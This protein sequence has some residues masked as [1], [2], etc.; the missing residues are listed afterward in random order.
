MKSSA[1]PAGYRMTRHALLRAHQRRISIT[2][3]ELVLR[4]GRLSRGN[5]YSLFGIPRPFGIGGRLWGQAAAVVVV[6]DPEGRIPTV[7]RRLNGRGGS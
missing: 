6:V 7:F 4:Y 1:A 3:I 5:R 2:M